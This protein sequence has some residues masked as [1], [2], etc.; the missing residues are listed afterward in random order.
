MDRQISWKLQ[1]RE[2][3]AKFPRR[4]RISP[5]YVDQMK[6]G[7]KTVADPLRFTKDLLEPRRKGCR[8]SD[9]F[10]RR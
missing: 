6:F 8:Y 3:V 7:P 5:T 10:V 2:H 4:F 1:F 9:R